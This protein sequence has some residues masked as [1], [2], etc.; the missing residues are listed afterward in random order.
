M[1]IKIVQSVAEAVSEILMAESFPFELYVPNDENLETFRSRLYSSIRRSSYQR[2]NL[3]D[4]S[5][6]QNNI[7]VVTIRN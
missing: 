5:T 7:L 6:E 2:Y 3:S 1:D 4:G